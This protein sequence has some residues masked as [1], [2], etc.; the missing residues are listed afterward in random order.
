[1][2]GDKGPLAEVGEEHRPDTAELWEAQDMASVCDLVTQPN[3]GAI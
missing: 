3:L 1:M 2:L